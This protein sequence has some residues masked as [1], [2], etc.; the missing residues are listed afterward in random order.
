MMHMDNLTNNYSPVKCCWL[1]QERSW[2]L[3]HP[4]QWAFHRGAWWHQPERSRQSAPSSHQTSGLLSPK[5][6]PSGSWS[7]PAQNYKWNVKDVVE[8][9]NITLYH[10]RHG[11]S[12]SI[13]EFTA[14]EPVRFN[15]TANTQTHL[16][17]KSGYHV[18]SHTSKSAKIST[19]T[20]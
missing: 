9:R 18:I 15:T 8:S 7:R 6:P 11:N 17:Q 20:S 10:S 2:W 13:V 16:S 3:W 14:H 1:R 19:S 12:M 5:L 4:S